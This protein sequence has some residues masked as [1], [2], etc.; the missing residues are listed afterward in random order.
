MKKAL[1]KISGMHCT[2]CAMLIDGDVED[3]QGVKAASTNF[4]KE[5][6]E[7]EFDEAKV[8][9]DTIISTIKETGYRAQLED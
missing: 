4:A 2:S 7:V 9:P 8:S 1:F 5:E 6:T 3:I